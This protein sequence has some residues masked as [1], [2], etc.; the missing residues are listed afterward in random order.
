MLS[1]IYSSAWRSFCLLGGCICCPLR[2]ESAVLLSRTTHR[3]VVRFN[4]ILSHFRKQKNLIVSTFV[5]NT[6]FGSNP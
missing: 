6:G 2:I 1:R 4:F 5:P 3:G